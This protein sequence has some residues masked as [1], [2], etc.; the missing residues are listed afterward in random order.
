MHADLTLICGVE[1]GGWAH[2]R[3]R[4]VALA[5][6]A[7]VPKLNDRKPSHGNIL[8]TYLRKEDKGCVT[9]RTIAIQF[10]CNSRALGVCPA[11]LIVVT[12]HARDNVHEAIGGRHSAHAGA[13]QDARTL[14]CVHVTWTA[15]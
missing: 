13:V 3:V 5:E 6:A 8:V 2:C 15:N 12:R 7:T 9:M 14:V 11:D 1:S 10:E 4:V